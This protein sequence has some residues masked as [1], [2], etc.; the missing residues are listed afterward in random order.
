MKPGRRAVGKQES[1]FALLF[2]F[3][4][5]AMVS[6]MLYMELPRVAF[7]AQREKEELLIERGEQYVRAIQ[8]YMRKF[9]GRYPASIDQLENTN[10]IRFLR[11]RYK[12]PMTNSDDWRLIHAGPGG[13]LLDSLVQKPPQVKQE[14]QMGS[15]IGTPIGSS[16]Q[17]SDPNAPAVPS[18]VPRLRPSESAGGTVV[19]PGFA[20]STSPGWNPEAPGQPVA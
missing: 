20:G 11:R 12:D 3:A 13:V 2:V 10:N 16:G 9:P 1:G 5:A 17:A 6:I 15:S 14:G 8:L 4:M 7:Q 19:M 18:M